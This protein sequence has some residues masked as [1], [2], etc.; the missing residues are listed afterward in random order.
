MLKS[1]YAALEIT[2]FVLFC[3]GL[4]LVVE[5]FWHCIRSICGGKSILPIALEHGKDFCF[6]CVVQVH[7]LKMSD[8]YREKIYKSHALKNNY[9]TPC[10]SSTGSM[11]GSR[12]RV[13]HIW[14]G[15]SGLE[16]AQLNVLLELQL[17]TLLMISKIPI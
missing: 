17:R 1:S 2:S 11:G 4:P 5:S 8:V 10:I 6:T 9:H 7:T 16:V 15:C 13:S 12:K 3:T 14:N